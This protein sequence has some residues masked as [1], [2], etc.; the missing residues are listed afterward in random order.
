MEEHTVTYQAFLSHNSA[1]KPAVEELARRLERA[2]ISTFLDKWHLIPGESWQPALEQAL[3][4]S[5]T[6]VV[7]VGPSGLGPWQNEEMRV[8]ISRRVSDTSRSFRVIP[9][10]LPGARREHRKRLPAFLVAATW[11]EF[12]ENLDEEEAF[13]RLECGIRGI[14][15]GPSPNEVLYPGE[16]PYRGLRVFDAEHARFFFGRESQIDWMSEHLVEGFGTHRDTRFLAVIGASGSGKSSLVRAGL[17]PALREGHTRNGKSVPG[18]SDWPIVVLKPGLE[19]LKALAD[20]LWSDATARDVIGDALDYAGRLK[21]DEHRLHATVGTV[22]HGKPSGHRFV[23]VVDQFEELF[24]LCPSD[25]EQERIRFIENLLYASSVVGGRTLVVITMRAD[26]YGR[27]TRYA[28]LAHALSEDQ[29]LVSPLGQNELR[30]AI[31]QPARLVGCEFESGLVERILQDFTDEANALP[32]LQHTLFELWKGRQSRKLTHAAYDDMGRLSG[33]LD[34][35]AE[36]VFGE[37]SETEQS[38]CRNIFLRLILPG[39][40]LGP[41]TKKRVRLNELPK[42]DGRNDAEGVLKRLADCRLLSMD[43]SVHG[44]SG[45]TVEIAHEALIRGWARLGEWVD[46]HRQS[47]RIHGRLTE[48]AREW[49]RSGR[50]ESYLYRGALLEG[51]RNWPL[52]HRGEL[53]STEAKF[54]NAS[55]DLEKERVLREQKDRARSSIS[56]LLG[57][58]L[59]LDETMPQVLNALFVV[60]PLA[61]RGFI[62]LQDIDGKLVPMCVKS[63]TQSEGDTIRISR[64]I[65]K[66][67]MESKEAILSAEAT[68]DDRLDMSQS[69]ADLRIRSMMCAPLLDSEGN[70]LGVVEVDTLDQRKPFCQEDLEL[71]ADVASQL[72]TAIHN[73]QLHENALRQN[74]I[75][76]DLEIAHEVQIGFLPQSRPDMSGYEFFDYYSPADQVGGDYYD[77]IQLPDG[78]MAVIVADVVGHGIAAAMMMVKLT[79]EANFCLVTENHP[80]TAITKL[81]DRFSTIL[82]D[83]FLTFVMAVIDPAEHEAT[84]VN[85]GHM[86]PIWRRAD[87]AIEEPGVDVSGMPIGIVEGMEY[88]QTVVSLA[89]GESLTM[90]T[91]GL[92]DAMD[93][94]GSYFSIERIRDHVRSG[95]QDLESVGRAIV[96]DVRQFVG[97]GPQADDMCLVMLRRK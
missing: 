63:R 55:L 75:R 26:F 83:R 42:R 82:N 35:Y 43:R 2:G 13:H 6:C 50:D 60:F 17:I 39:D 9:V 40:E 79:A 72:G 48:A 37:F 49:D 29:E 11:V 76:R 52:S 78:R 15:P 86:P 71:L 80:A 22:L 92:N 95:T 93:G 23:I 34:R 54:L 64:T 58:T 96:D 36:R 45:V 46:T 88:K 44:E 69:S 87:G 47:L 81:N 77:Y 85:A 10:V 61:D 28:R 56:R 41:D 32:L 74:E 70:A 89:E 59:S 18:S 12:A 8:A 94:S 90:F 25:S 1:D 66:D 20:A 53:N 84:I 31:E 14:V 3:D 91:D 33:A 5:E 30:S 97:E 16:C 73:A 67:V 21:S 19:P 4:E 38:Q 62:V 68:R 57:G 51:V 27:C 7:F 24:T 65:V